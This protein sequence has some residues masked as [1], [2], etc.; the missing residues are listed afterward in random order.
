MSL[1]VPACLRIIFF[2]VFNLAESEW[3]LEW[4]FPWWFAPYHAHTDFAT[5]QIP[6]DSAYQ[7][8]EINVLQSALVFPGV[9]DEHI[10]QSN[11]LQRHPHRTSPGDAN[12]RALK[13][14]WQ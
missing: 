14:V 10:L 11:P 8:H 4:T 3:A 5:L 13:N 6:R 1:I 2:S 7:D 12:T 9:H